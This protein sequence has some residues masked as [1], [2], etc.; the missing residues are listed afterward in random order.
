MVS[1]H[2]EGDIVSD[3]LKGDIVL[4]HHEVDI[5][6]VSRRTSPPSVIILYARHTISSG[7]SSHVSATEITQRHLA[8]T[9][10][11]SSHMSQL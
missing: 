7:L 8:N 11:N 5:T 3:H 1:D 2:L 6:R 4:S 10:E 9:C